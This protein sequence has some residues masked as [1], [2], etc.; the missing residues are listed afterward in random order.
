MPESPAD[1]SLTA[2][3]FLEHQAQLEQEAREA[4][5]YE[6][7]TCTYPRPLRQHVFAC[8]TC[9]RASA[10][11]V[12]VCYLCLI[13]CHSTHDLVELFSKRHFACDCGTGRMAGGAACAV[14]ARATASGGSRPFSAPPLPPASDIESL[15][16]SYNHNYAGRFCSCAAPYDPALERRT[17]HQCY[18]GDAC[19]E[20][21]YHQEC[22]LGYVP[23]LF[24][25]PRAH[26][27]PHF[28]DEDAFVEFV[29]WRCVQR[30][31]RAFAELVACAGVVLATRPHLAGA[32]SADTWRSLAESGPGEKGV[33]RP[34]RSTLPRPRPAP[35]SV[36]LAPGFHARLSALRGRLPPGSALRKLL[37]AFGFL[38]TEEPVHQPAAD[39]AAST[40]AAEGSLYDLG[41]T[42]LRS[43]PIP[44]AL[45]GLEA[46]DAMKEK[47]RGFFKDFVEKK[48]VVTE[49]E[50]RA[51]FGRM[52]DE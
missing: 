51:F 28:P 49:E 16:N 24:L 20:D 33:K 14:R 11:A 12:G 1:S 18:L 27:V 19:G 8:L 47:L 2:A 23:G 36:F 35:Y 31:G 7:D 9:R 22:I 42:A 10:A 32:D 29:C 39:G 37:E 48:K 4:M 44:Q 40:P 50:V 26:A 43:L 25:G 13:Q 34:R 46:Y 15:G 17:M 5:P 45:E 38:V 52:E 41:S 30:H 3:D 6:P 21:W